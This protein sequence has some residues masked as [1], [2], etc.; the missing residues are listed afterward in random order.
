VLTVWDLE[1]GKERHTLKGPSSSI[2]GVAFS[3]DGKYVL[4]GSGGGTKGFGELWVWDAATG[5]PVRSVLADRDQV[6]SFSV[7]PDSR[8]VATMGYDRIVRVWDIETGKELLAFAGHKKETPGDSMAVA[9]SPDGRLIA[10]GI[11]GREGMLRLWDARTGKEVHAIKAHGLGVRALAFSPKGDLLATGGH[12]SNTLVRDDTVKLW[13]VKTGK[14][15]SSNTRYPTESV[16]TL[17]FSADGEWLA[18]GAYTKV[19]VWELTK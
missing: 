15:V 7:S 5:K 13:D 6:F 18:V 4:S 17:A 14:M 19:T 16:H 3:P 1:S 11:S 8:R 2:L 12:G 10:S 9:F